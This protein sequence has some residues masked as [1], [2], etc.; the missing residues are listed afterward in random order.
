MMTD[1]G[2]IDRQTDK[3]VGDMTRDYSIA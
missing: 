1:G 3:P 2:Q